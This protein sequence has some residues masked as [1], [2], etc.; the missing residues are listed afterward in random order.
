MGSK[1]LTPA[2]ALAALREKPLIDLMTEADAVRR[3][4]H[5]G[6]RV[7]FVI[8][9]NPNYTNVCV[10]DCT[11]CS[12]Y[13]KPGH[14]DGY[15]LDPKAVGEKARDAQGLG[16]TTVLLQGGHNPDLPFQYYLDLI[17]AVGASAPGMHRHFFSPPEIDH[18]A[19]TCAMTLE[20]VLRRFW[21]A[22]LRTM[23]GG[24]AEILS[25]GV[26][27]RV[28][29]KKISADR[30]IEIMRAAHGVGMKTSATM[31]YGHVESDTD[32]I[33]HLF[34]LRAL[35]D[36]TGGFYA[37]IPWSFKPGASPLS[38]L[39]EATALPS[40]YLRVIAVSRLVLDNIPHIQASWF[41][42][43]WRAG[44]LALNAG[45]DDFGGLLIEEN[46]LFQ[47]KHTVATSM[48][49]MLRT[50]RESGFV[51]AQRT[52]L[53]ETLQEYTSPIPEE[54][55]EPPS[56]ERTARPALSRQP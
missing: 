44:Q 32:I 35:Q 49:G 47:A 36:E 8:D 40:Y 16:A 38:K 25:D 56:V 6:N 50:I 21:D 17:E 10:T 9:T 37:F 1:R 24:G 53:Y 3:A 43:G 22:G 12:F 19:R 39:V 54:S 13:R 28:S 29:P 27:R 52:T 34:R 15:T 41:G 11:F 23:P 42:E 2:A 14:A 55:L 31:T 26:R 51:P 20:T 5:P 45:A 30:W 46:V 18:I 33:E 7:T 4:M 48:G